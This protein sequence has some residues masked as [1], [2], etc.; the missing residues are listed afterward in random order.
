MT[1]AGLVF[2]GGLHRSG[3]TLLAR[4]L[5]AHPA[6]AGLS[7]TGVPEDEGQHLQ[8]VL[9][10]A[11]AMGGPGRFALRPEAHLTE[12]S[13]LVSRDARERLLRAWEPYW[14]RTRPLLLEKSPPNL[15]RTRFLQALFAQQRH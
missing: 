12:S 5:A 10:T 13:P 2:V 11:Q 4:C 14:D 15:L 9:P 3:T 7:R 8:D 6:I 1:V